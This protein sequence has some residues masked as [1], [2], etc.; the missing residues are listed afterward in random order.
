[1][2]KSPPP[3]PAP[4]SVKESP[5][6]PT[7]EELKEETKETPKEKEVTPPSAPEWSKWEP[8]EGAGWDGNWR[9]RTGEDGK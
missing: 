6:E 8:I 3:A 9:A 2:E 1:M 4:P 7:K 5:K